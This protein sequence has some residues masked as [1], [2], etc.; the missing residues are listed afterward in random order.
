[1]NSLYASL[2][3]L[4]VAAPAGNRWTEIVGTFSTQLDS[5]TVSVPRDGD[6]VDTFWLVFV[7]NHKAEADARVFR[8]GDRVRVRGRL[9]AGGV[10]RYVVVESI[11]KDE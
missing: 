6:E 8:D 9:G 3:A 10:Y 4:A 11:A 2:L 7:N 5:P 1:M